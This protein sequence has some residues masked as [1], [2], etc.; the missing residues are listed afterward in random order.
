MKTKLLAGLIAACCAAPV[1]AQSN[2]TIY[3]IADAGLHVS[4][5][6]EGTKTKLVSGIADGS[7]LGFKGT[8]DLGGGYKAIFNIESRIELDTGGNQAGN[9]S[10]NQGFALSKGMVFPAPV[11]QLAPLAAG[12]LAAAQKA[13][14]PAINVNKNGALF[15]RTSMVGLI[16]PVGAILAGRMYTPAYE[17]FAAADTFETGTAGS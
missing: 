7:R 6:G 12:A 5:N 4:S 3:G 16:T 2:I 14:Q 11:P 1:L 13:M 9:I 8:E 15:D 10:D 17:V